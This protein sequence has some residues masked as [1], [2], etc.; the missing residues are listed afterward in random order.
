MLDGVILVLPIHARYRCSSKM[1]QSVVSFN[2]VCFLTEQ[3]WHI[4]VMH[5]QI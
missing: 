3:A 5:S 1:F 2:Y 4:L